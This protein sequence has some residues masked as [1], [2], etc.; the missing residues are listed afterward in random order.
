M[1]LNLCI[2]R[3][4]RKKPTRIP[5]VTHLDQIGFL[6]SKI[7][8]IPSTR[9][10]C[11]H[12]VGKTLEGTNDF[13]IL[14][15]AVSDFSHDQF[16]FF[17]SKKTKCG[18]GLVN[19]WWCQK[20]YEVDK[21]S[22]D[23][24][25][26]LKLSNAA[27]SLVG[28]ALFECLSEMS[29]T[30]TSSEFDEAPTCSYEDEDYGLEL[31]ESEEVAVDRTASE[32]K[33]PQRKVTSAIELP[34]ILNP[35]IHIKPID[36][37]NKTG[38]KIIELSKKMRALTLALEREKYSNR[39]LSTRL[40]VRT[41][42]QVQTVGQTDPTQPNQALLR[43]KADSPDIRSLKDR[44]KQTI[45]KLEE[46]R[47]AHQNLKVELRNTQKVLAMEVGQDVSVSKVL[48]GKSGWKG[49]AQQIHILKLEL[50]QN[51][52]VK[53][54]LREHSLCG[55]F[56]TMPK[57]D[58]TPSSDIRKITEKRQESIDQLALGY[59]ELLKE[60]SDLK[61]RFE[62]GQARNKYLEKDIRSLKLKIQLLIEKSNFLGFIQII[63]FNSFNRMKVTPKR[64][65]V[66][67]NRLTG[68]N[69]HFS[70]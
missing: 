23:I 12:T 36:S 54:R 17:I 52:L 60:H 64:N 8:K 44:L 39:D 63:N 15:R 40:K 4:R 10:F 7:W 57:H 70:V 50:T 51:L 2:S 28:K 42:I 59:K 6:T 31:A 45:R 48:A 33:Q 38:T 30:D 41:A 3:S 62:G 14:K 37:G 5:L 29:N 43:P 13:D 22:S 25:I 18:K 32:P 20:I 16:T 34:P 65:K 26:E 19:Q 49:R 61:L 58:Q 35:S 9:G 46:E 11:L 67:M 55:S 24:R 66:Q 69:Y 1:L 47:M 27:V 56:P 53:E 68:S 21:L